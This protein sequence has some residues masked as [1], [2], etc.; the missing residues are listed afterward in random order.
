[1][2]LDKNGIDRLL[3]LDD[4]GL[5]SVIRIIASQSGI[6]LPARADHSEISAI[7]NALGSASDADIAAAASLLEKF[8]DKNG[9]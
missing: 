4:S 2:Q 6:N 5:W 1:M 7:R 9:G 3:L 8:K